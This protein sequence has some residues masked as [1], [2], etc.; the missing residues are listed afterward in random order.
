LK[1]KFTARQQIQIESKADMKKRGM[2]S[3]DRADALMLTAGATPLPDQVVEDEDADDVE[4][5]ISLY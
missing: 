4:G 5:S 1:Y 2:P 3:P